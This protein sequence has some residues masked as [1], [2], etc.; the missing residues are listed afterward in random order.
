MDDH[1]EEFIDMVLT[2]LGDK[3][4]DR[5]EC[6]Q[7]A[8]VNEFWDKGY[9][10]VVFYKAREMVDKYEGKVWPMRFIKSPWPNTGDTGELYGKLKDNVEK[11]NS[12]NFFVLQGILTPDTELIKK[13]ILDG[14]GLSI[15]KISDRCSG[16][17]VDWVE[18]EW[19]PQQLLNIVIVDFFEN[20]SILPS[21]INYNRK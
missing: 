17:V 16:K 18:E 3:V 9:Q 4:A 7:K 8:T 19:K 11:R 13:E 21:I 2:S 5:D 12:N 20:C 1:H 10:A 14:G 6:D 15:K